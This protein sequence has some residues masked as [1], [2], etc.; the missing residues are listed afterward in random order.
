VQN[1]DIIL[2]ISDG[3]KMIFFRSHFVHASQS[4]ER[5]VQ[6]EEPK[7]VFHDKSERDCL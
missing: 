5:R 2:Y 6:F 1:D 4:L 7:H 3:H